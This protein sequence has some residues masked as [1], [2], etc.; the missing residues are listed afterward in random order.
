MEKRKDTFLFYI[1]NNRKYWW[2]RTSS[3]GNIVGSSTQGYASKAY[4]KEN[5]VR[6][7]YDSNKHITVY[8][9]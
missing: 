8:E 2:R 9:W 4:C 3:N 1:G 7:G 6:N 5:A